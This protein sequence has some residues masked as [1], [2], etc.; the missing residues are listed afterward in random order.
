MPPLLK[1][2]AVNMNYLNIIKNSICWTPSISSHS[3]TQIMSNFC[4]GNRGRWPTDPSIGDAGNFPFTRM[5]GQVKKSWQA[6]QK[7]P[8]SHVCQLDAYRKPK[9]IA[10]TLYDGNNPLLLFLPRKW[11]SLSGILTLKML[12][13]IPAEPW[14]YLMLVGIWEGAQDLNDIPMAPC[15]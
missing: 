15:I 7:H 11:C 13:Y 10:L 8:A 12:Q 3:F 9:V 6:L 2:D 5:P 1:W 4:G 14:T